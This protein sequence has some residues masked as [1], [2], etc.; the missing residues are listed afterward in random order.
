MEKIYKHWEIFSDDQ[1]TNVVVD[2]HWRDT[3]REK[4]V[5]VGVAHPFL[6]V[7][8]KGQYGVPPQGTM[9]VRNEKGIIHEIHGRHIERE[10]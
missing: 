6:Y 2:W 7:G 4:G 3:P 8:D 1:H 10:P 9:L 5:L